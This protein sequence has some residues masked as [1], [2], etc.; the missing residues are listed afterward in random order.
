MKEQKQFKPS[1]GILITYIFVQVIPA[2][3]VVFFSQ[4]GAADFNVRLM[5]LSSLSSFVIGAIIMITINQASRFTTPIDD[6]PVKKGR[7]FAWGLMGLP[8]LLIGQSLAGLIEV[9]LLNQPESSQNTMMIIEMI[10]Q[11]PIYTLAITVAGPIM[12]E[13]VFRKVIFA[14]LFNRTGAVGAAVISSLLFAFVHLDGHILLY[15][16]MGFV[17]CLVYYKA[18]SVWAPIASHALMNIF[19]LVSAWVI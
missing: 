19:A 4:P 7:V 6:R 11:Y 5:I 12:E 16:V 18:G 2:L 8:L 1:L 15:S 13:F 14:N 17:F 10:R 3:L 9:N